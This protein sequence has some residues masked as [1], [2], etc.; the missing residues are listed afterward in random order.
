MKNEQTMQEPVLNCAGKMLDITRP[1][2]MG[3]LN[4]TPDSFWDGG[5]LP[6]V[7]DQLKQV[8]KMLYEGR[9]PY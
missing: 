7:S 9:F 6:T 1:V 8:E 4:V 2:V 5:S 3:I